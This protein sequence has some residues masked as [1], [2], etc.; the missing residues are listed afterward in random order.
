M[1]YYII[2][3]ILL[4]II[5]FLWIQSQSARKTLKNKNKEL[6]SLY[7]ETEKQFQLQQDYISVLSQELRTP[8]YGIMGL[9]N[10]LAEDHPELKNNRKLKSLKFSGD[11]LLTLINN[12][13]HVNYLD[14]EEIQPQ[15]IFFDLKEITQNLVD[16]F[17]Y[18]TENSDN[19]LHFDFD[20]EIDQSI[21][22]D[23][24][25]LSQILMNLISNALRFTKNGNVY[26]S[27]SLIKKKGNTATI[28]FKIKHDGF[29]VTK[30]DK[31]SIYQE[32]IGVDKAKKSYLGTG[33]NFTIVKKL[34]KALQGEIIIQDDS[35]TG[36]EYAFATDFEVLQN[37]D[38][39]KQ[40]SK[41]SSTNTKLKVL[42]V[43]DN[44]LN[45]LVAE[46]M[47]SK[48]N[49]D[50]TTIDNGFDAI[51]LVRENTYSIV[52]MDIN[53]PKLN[54]IGTTKRIRE[55]DSKTPIIALTAVDVTQLNSQIIQA[56]LNDY[57]LKPYNKNH[58]LEII[59][60][61]LTP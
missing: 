41:T 53:M 6:Q 17:S 21:N 45:L 30:E 55:F 48:E 3:G 43:D 22:G 29:E 54:G 34:A 36:S 11:Y 33:L 1:A 46:K 10:L 25:I 61:N 38:S 4:A 44:K 50:C 56:G 16:S 12:I 13:L 58:L 57:I 42:I 26:F 31:N 18:A 51:E 14:S 28:S 60:K 32:F 52:L 19:I 27:V 47:L 24:A 23:P 20:S 15:H 39:N 37:E 5:L 59:S 7:T 40:F 8:L 35:Q 9:T 49:Y 2:G